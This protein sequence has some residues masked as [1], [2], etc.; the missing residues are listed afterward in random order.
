MAHAATSFGL[1]EMKLNMMAHIK[2]G[3]NEHDRIARLEEKVDSMAAD[4][5]RIASVL[6]AQGSSAKATT[7]TYHPMPD[8]SDQNDSFSRAERANALAG[9]FW[10]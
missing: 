2:E 3:D 1:D 4:L 6:E 10:A 7:S 5:K 9:G 8:V